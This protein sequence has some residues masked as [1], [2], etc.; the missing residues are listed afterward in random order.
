MPWPHKRAL[1]VMASS[2]LRYSQYSWL[3]GRYVHFIFNKK[4]MQLCS[5]WSIFT[6]IFF[7]YVIF[8]YK[9]TISFYLLNTPQFSSTIARIDVESARG[10][11]VKGGGGELARGGALESAQ[12]GQSRGGGGE[13]ARAGES[14]GGG[15]G[16]GRVGPSRRVPRW[17]S[18]VSPSRRVPSLS[19]RWRVSPSRRVP[20]LSWRWRVGPRGSSQEQPKKENYTKYVTFIVT[21]QWGAVVHAI[22][23]AENYEQKILIFIYVTRPRGS[24]QE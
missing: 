24:S 23:Y 1:A 18:R 7:T 11:G 19:W 14:R 2:P 10:S 17:S 4:P 9:F 13:L 6:R 3:K 20:S 5:S 16:G 8:S 22:K 12:A 21:S 15:G